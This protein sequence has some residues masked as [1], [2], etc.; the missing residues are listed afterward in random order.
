MPVN[1]VAEQ[2]AG[3]AGSFERFYL[4]TFRTQKDFIFLEDHLPGGGITTSALIGW[5][6]GKGL[7][8]DI[9]NRHVQALGRTKLEQKF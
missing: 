6:P 9:F 5:R 7:E 2:A 3:A 4:V 8:S 1:P